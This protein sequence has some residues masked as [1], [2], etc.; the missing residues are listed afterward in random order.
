MHHATH[1]YA[2]CHTHELDVLHIR[3]S[4]TTHMNASRHTCVSIVSHTWIRHVIH[5]NELNHTYECITTHMLPTE[6]IRFK[7]FGSLEI[8]QFSWYIFWVTRTGYTLMKTCMKVW[9]LPW[10]RVLYVRGLPWKLVGKFGCPYCF[11]SDLLRVWCKHRV[12]HINKTW[13]TYEWVLSHM[14]MHHATHACA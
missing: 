3:M 13:N 10:N 12:T 8:Y 6:E 5:M 11:K 1:L 2:T 9:G 14:W 4:H 7:T